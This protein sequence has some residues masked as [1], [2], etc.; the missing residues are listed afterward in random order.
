M[1]KLLGIWGEVAEENQ[2]WHEQT[3]IPEATMRLGTRAYHFQAG[4]NMFPDE[5]AQTAT[6]F[7]LY[8]PLASAGSQLSTEQILSPAGPNSDAPEDVVLDARYYTCEFEDKAEGFSG[9][10]ASTAAQSPCVVLTSLEYA[11][12][13][14]LVMGMFQPPPATHDAFFEWWHTDFEPFIQRSPEFLRARLWKLDAAADLRH[15][16]VQK[17]DG[18]DLLPYIMMFEF[19]SYDLP[20]EVAV[21]I[22]QSKS[23]QEFV[24]KDLVCLP[25]GRRLGRCL[26]AYRSIGTGCTTSSGY[27]RRRARSKRTSRAMRTLTRKAKTKPRMNKVA[28]TRTLAAPKTMHLPLSTTIMHHSA[29]G[30]VTCTS[31]PCTYLALSMKQ[32]FPRPSST[33]VR[34]FGE[35]T[36]VYAG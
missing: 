31:T 30:W 16:T 15:Q 23:Y 25:L 1:S 35:C 19:Q 18:D 5:H 21:E 27:T 10:T 8:D 34:R 32:K 12:A 22:G 33:V 20:W 28:L 2:E 9:G 4:E 3:Q 6:S 13:G 17:R 14:C 11:D 36:S 26:R 24:E 7:T 29:R